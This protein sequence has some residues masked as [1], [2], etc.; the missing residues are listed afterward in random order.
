MAVKGRSRQEILAAFERRLNNDA[1]AE[2]AT[3]LAEIDRIALLRL[4][5]ICP[6]PEANA[7]GDESHPLQFAYRSAPRAGFIG[8]PAT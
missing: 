7:G 4:R 3:A 8:R 5:D 6:A 1:A 2:T